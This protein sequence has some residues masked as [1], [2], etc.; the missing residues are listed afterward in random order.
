[1]PLVLLLAVVFPGEGG[2]GVGGGGGGGI[3][4]MLTENDFCEYEPY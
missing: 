2:V 3:N 4:V 1:M